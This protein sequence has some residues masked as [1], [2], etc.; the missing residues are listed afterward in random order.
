MPGEVRRRTL[1]PAKLNLSLRVL[2]REASGYHQIETLFCAL[3]LADE[4]EISHTRDGVTLEVAAPAG[5]TGPPP[6]L[7]PVEQNLAFRAACLFIAECPLSHGIHI[8]LVKRVPAGAG[9][10]GG[11]SDAAAV[12][13]VLNE[14]L[15][16]PLPQAALL[17][18][19]VQLGADVPFFLTGAGL[20]LAWGRGERILPLPPLEAVPVVLAVPPERISTADAYAALEGTRAVRAGVIDPPRSWNDVASSAHNDFEDLVFARHP[21]IAAVRQALEDG[22]ARIARM[23]GT[24]SV[25][26]GVFDDVATA[27][28]AA[29]DL[30]AAHEDVEMI[31]TQTS[32]RGQVAGQ[33]R[34]AER[35]PRS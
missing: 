11:S 15:S 29:S 17:E 35:G 32:T 9:L 20:A 3:E 33:G 24:G 23:T 25:V 7:G 22:G 14:M 34:D 13:R 8:R 10:G 30:A 28:A 5:A 1:A 21:R 6:V 2:A 16:D 4:I 31:V 27:E 26:F 19:G 18:L 12:L